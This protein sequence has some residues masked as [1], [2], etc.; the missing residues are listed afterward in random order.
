MQF[1]TISLILLSLF[2]GCYFC[3]MILQRAKGIKTDQLGNNKSGKAKIIEYTMKI[4]AIVTPLTEIVSICLNLSVLPPFA[5]YIGA[6]TATSGVILFIISVT[7]MKENWRAGVGE[8][9]KTELVT[10]GIYKFSRNPAF[11]GFDLLYIGIVFMFF[12]VSLLL[13]SLA[14]VVLFH[15]QIVMVEEPFLAKNFK[16]DYLAYKNNTNRYI[17]RKHH[18]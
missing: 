5:R 9:E 16:D 10:N 13:I 4:I 17:G 12:N 14:G 18:H 6:A 15:F 11:L 3:K 8:K 7:A 1:Q 2:Y